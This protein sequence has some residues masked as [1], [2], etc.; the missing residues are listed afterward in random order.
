MFHKLVLKK[1]RLWYY[2]TG[3]EKIKV[4]DGLVG[5]LEMKKSQGKIEDYKFE[6]HGSLFVKHKEDLGRIGFNSMS[7]ESKVPNE[8]L[9]DAKADQLDRE[10]LQN[11]LRGFASSLEKGNY[12]IFSGS[13][14]RGGGPDADFLI[15]ALKKIISNKTL[16]MEDKKKKVKELRSS[17]D[18]E[19]VIEIL[20]NL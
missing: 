19:T 14:N 16:S 18:E 6:A 9:S 3:K 7:L 1:Y 12:I 4:Y 20:N 11:T 2:T 5:Y 10:E 17:W 13:H 15:P 8:L